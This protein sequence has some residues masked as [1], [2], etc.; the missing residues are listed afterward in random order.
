MRHRKDTQMYL[1]IHEL[2]DEQQSAGQSRVG[3]AITW[4]IVTNLV[5]FFGLPEAKHVRLLYRWGVVPWELTHQVDLQGDIRVKEGDKELVL[6]HGRALISPNLNLFLYQFLHVDFMHLFAN[7]YMLWIFGPRIEKLF[8]RNFFLTFYLA[9]GAIAAIAEVF[10]DIHSIGVIVGASGSIY[11]VLGAY[12]VLY[13]CKKIVTL[14]VP[15]FFMPAVMPACLVIAVI[16][17]LDLSYTIM[18]PDSPICGIAH[19]CGFV[20]GAFVAARIRYL[21][22]LSTKRDNAS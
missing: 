8:G 19:I 4:I 5:L 10:S 14:V 6:P 3:P 7:M 9:S 2:N 17:A 21:V 22:W 12:V 13:P 15:L 18:K 11:A 16:V 20:F 1:P